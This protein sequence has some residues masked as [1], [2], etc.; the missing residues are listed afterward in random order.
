MVKGERC[1]LQ[2]S[3]TLTVTVKCHHTTTSKCRKN[4]VIGRQGQEEG[5]WDQPEAEREVGQYLDK[6]RHNTKIT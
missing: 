2:H 1:V 6:T 5:E 4:I 3:A